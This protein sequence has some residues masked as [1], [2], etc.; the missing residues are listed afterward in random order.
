MYLYQEPFV[1]IHE[2]SP[3]PME[4]NISSSCPD[5][6][7]RSSTA[8]LLL[9]V[10]RISTLIIT[11]GGGVNSSRTNMTTE[12][13]FHLLVVWVNTPASATASCST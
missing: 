1:R 13:K 7:V 6:D 5:E 2:S 4:P 8:Y 11:P 9:T 10:R 3:V 12:D